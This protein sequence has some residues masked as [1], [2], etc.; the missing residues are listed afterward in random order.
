MFTRE[1]KLR[2]F[3]HFYQL[4]FNSHPEIKTLFEHTDFEKQTTLLKHALS[5]AIMFAEDDNDLAKSVLTQIRKSHSRTKLNIKPKYYALWLNCLMH[6]FWV[7]D[8]QFNQALEKN[9]RTL[10]Q[11]SIDYIREG[12]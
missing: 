6:T 4:F 5:M 12:Y 9:W 3:K 7:C 10:L 2:F 1:S 11:I 8:P